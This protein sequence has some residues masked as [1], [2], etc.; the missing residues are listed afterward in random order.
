MKRQRIFLVLVLLCLP[1]LCFV[2][3]AWAGFE[4]LLEKDIS[5]KNVS[6]PPS[7]VTF[8]I[9]GSETAATPITSQT[10]TPGNWSVDIIQ[11]YPSPN[12][13]RLKV[14]FTN[15]D[16]LTNNVDYW[17]EVELDGSATGGRER[18]KKEAWALFSAE[19]VNANDVY[20]KDINP[21]SVSITGYGTVINSN[22]QWVGD[23]TG[24]QGPPGPKG[25][26]GAAGPQ[27]I[28]G[29]TGPQGLTGATGPAGP[30]G[31]QGAQGLT[32]TQGPQ[33]LTGATGP[34]GPQGPTGPQGPKGD[35]GATGPQGPPAPSALCTWSNVTYSTGAVC[36]PSSSCLCNGTNYFKKCEANG[37]WSDYPYQNSNCN[38]CPDMCGN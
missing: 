14:I 11:K 16:V 13:Y 32:G 28:Q 34:Q 3:S 4:I 18:I 6:T 2:A 24:L 5:T 37:T 35:T 25:D 27:G 30:A 10:F 29:A 8:N 9:Y 19:A 21:K 20:N 7:N 33:G 36:M 15:T 26:T 23:P 31:Q 12:I 1:V 22:G 17:V 38:Y